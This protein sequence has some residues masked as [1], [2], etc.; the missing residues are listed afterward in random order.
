MRLIAEFPNGHISPVIVLL[1]PFA[2]Y[3]SRADSFFYFDESGERQYIC[4]LSV[5]QWAEH[6]RAKLTGSKRRD[7]PG[8]VYQ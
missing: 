6:N 5:E 2:M 8:E 4:T 7:G 1:S 3:R